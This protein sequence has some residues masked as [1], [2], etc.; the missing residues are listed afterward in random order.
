MTWYIHIGDDIARDQKIRMH[1]CRHINDE[2][3]NEDLIFEGKLFECGNEY[4]S[5][6]Y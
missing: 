1:F 2:F 5:I 3:T 6:K 4:D